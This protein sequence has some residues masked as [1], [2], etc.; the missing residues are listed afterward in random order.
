MRI[1]QPIIACLLAL[2]TSFTH[3]FGQK[4]LA[5]PASAPAIQQAAAALDTFLR[6]QITQLRIPGMQV[7]VVQGGRLVF[8]KSYGFANLQDSSS[9]RQQKQFSPLTPAPRFLPEWP[10]CNWLEDGKVDLSAPISRYVDG[11]PATWN[12]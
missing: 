9:S 7:A 12:P 3:T 11:L 1:Y 8:N 10:S 4:K 6:G 5:A 2:L